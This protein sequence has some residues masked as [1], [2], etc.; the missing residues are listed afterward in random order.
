MLQIL[1]KKD[2]D[3]FVFGNWGHVMRHMILILIVIL[4]VFWEAKRVVIILLIVIR[5]WY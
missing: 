5:Q 1:L 4:I 3:V 2:D